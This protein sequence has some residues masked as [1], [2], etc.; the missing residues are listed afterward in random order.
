[1]ERT[2]AEGTTIP[3]EREN[4]LCPICHL[5]GR[6]EDGCMY[7]SHNCK[8]IQDLMQKGK[9]KTFLHI[10]EKLYAA[11]NENG[12]IK[13]CTHC[14]RLTT[15]PQPGSHRHYDIGPPIP[16]KSER[17]KVLGLAPGASLYAKQC[18]TNYG[19]DLPEKFARYQKLYDFMCYLNTEYIGKISANIAYNL[20]KEVFIDAAVPYKAFFTSGLT[21]PTTDEEE[22]V[23]T[24]VLEAVEAKS[25]IKPAECGKFGPGVAVLAFKNAPNIPR[26]PT[27]VELKPTIL[28]QEPFNESKLPEAPVPPVQ[29]V[30]IDLPEGVTQ[31]NVNVN[32]PSKFNSEK[33][34]KLAEYKAKRSQYQKNFMAYQRAT[35]PYRAL[36]LAYNKELDTLAKKCKYHNERH[37]DGRDLIQFHHRQTDGELYDHEDSFICKEGLV[38]WLNFLSMEVKTVTCFDEENCDGFIHPDEVKDLMTTPE[39]TR[40]WNEYRR[41]FNRNPP[42]VLVPKEGGRRHPRFRRSRK[43]KKVL[44]TRKAKRYNRTRKQ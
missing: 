44:N 2:A 1:M 33:Q 41:R 26:P 25:L 34:A 39:E 8:Q 30:R 12:L 24:A 27:N 13:W 22:L 19:G 9:E 6:W 37:S 28:K 5:P 35:G 16:I 38:D 7:L 21:D 43:F 17:P 40:I 29:P 10:H 36:K 32:D 11:Y 31:T 42:D 20:I 15:D 4:S 14:N 18:Y 23:V 3:A